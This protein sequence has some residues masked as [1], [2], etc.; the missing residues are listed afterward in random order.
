MINLKHTFSPVLW[1]ISTLGSTGR[2]KHKKP[3]TT[4]TEVA[5][6]A[7]THKLQAH[8]SLIGL[9]KLPAQPN[10][11]ACSFC[12]YAFTSYFAFSTPYQ[13]TGVGG[14]LSIGQGV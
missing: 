5:L 10:C 12:S 3:C 6:H 9:H 14:L 11:A 4:G 1:L 13:F 7:G 2:M 8:P